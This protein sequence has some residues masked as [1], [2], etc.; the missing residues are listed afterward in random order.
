MGRL[1]VFATLGAFSS[2]GCFVVDDKKDDEGDAGEDSGG[3]GGGAGTN[4][5]G[6][7]SG[8]KATG[9]VSGTGTTGGASGTGGGTGDAVMKFCN[10]LTKGGEDVT[11]TVDFGGVRVS[12]VTGTCTPAV[13]LNC[14]TV[15]TG[16]AVS[17]NLYDGSTLLFEGQFT[18]VEA[19]DEVITLAVLDDAGTAPAL[20]GGVLDPGYVCSELDYA[21]FF[22]AALEAKGFDFKN[23]STKSMRALRGIN[24]ER[25]GFAE[26]IP[27]R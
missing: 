23:T 1:F 7:A 27:L 16:E 20:Q 14:T 5:K 11:L 9:G 26:L 13:G 6:G 3:T 25:A 19:G 17:A 10:N 15:P 24:A 4:S 22:T 12:T 2:A 21:D 18:L 8:S